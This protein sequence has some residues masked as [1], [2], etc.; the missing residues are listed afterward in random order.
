MA[1]M[2][3]DLIPA[4][5]GDEAPPL[6]IGGKSQNPA[7]QASTDAAPA[8]GGMF[9]DLVP[10]TKPTVGGFAP[11]S[12]REA[13][14]TREQTLD[15]YREMAKGIRGRQGTVGKYLDTFARGVARVVPV[16]DDIAAAGDYYLPKD[17]YKPTSYQDALDRVRAMNADDDEHR[18]WT[19]TAGTVAGSL[20]TLP[21]LPGG[22]AAK[23]G[24]AAAEQAGQIAA[25]KT[26]AMRAAD[27]GQIAKIGAVYGGLYGFGQGDAN[28][29]DRATKTVVGAGLGSVIAPV[30]NAVLTPAIGLAARGAN[31]AGRGIG[32]LANRIGFGKTAEAA[33][34]NEMASLADEFGVNLS[35]G[36]RTG[37]GP[38]I[39]R[40]NAIQ[41]GA[42]GPLAQEEAMLSRDAQWKQINEARDRIGGDLAGE[43]G[44]VDTPRDAGR[45]VADS[46]A[47]RAAAEENSLA[48]RNAAQRAVVDELNVAVPQ[49]AEKEAQAVADRLGRQSSMDAA[50]DVGDALRN[51]AEAGRAQYRAAY[52]DAMERPGSVAPEFF[53][54]VEN[55]AGEMVSPTISQ[56]IQSRLLAEGENPVAALEPAAAQ[57]LDDL[58]AFSR[59]RIGKINDPSQEVQLT[60][61]AVE[62]ARKV[63]QRR[64][65]AASNDSDKRSMRK[66]IG[67]FDDEV[68]NMLQSRLYSGDPG[69]LN[70]FR[71][72]RGLYRSFQQQFRPQG[73]GDDVG[74]AL[75]RIVDHNATPEEVSNLL[76]GGSAVGARGVNARLVERVTQLFGKDSEQVQAI[77][78][79]VWDRIV[80][81][82][83][84]TSP[85]DAEKIADRIREFTQGYGRSV[86]QALYSPDELANM[87]TLQDAMRRFSAWQ[88]A[89]FEAQEAEGMTRS[90]IDIARKNF[91]PDDLA[92]KLVGS[93]SASSRT[94]NMHA[95]GVVEA[96]FGK[97]SPE[98]S[99]V[100]QAMWK[101]T[102]TKPDGVN[103]FGSQALSKRIFELV[104]GRG[105][106]IAD[107]L[108]TPE[109]IGEMRRFATLV[110]GTVTEGK[111]GI[112]NN[113]GTFGPMAHA[114]MKRNI[115]A[116]SA[117]IGAAV[118]GAGGAAA[119]VG[120][121]QGL[122]KIIDRRAAAAAR[123][124]F[125]D[126]P[127]RAAARR[128][129]VQSIG[130]KASQL[131]AAIPVDRFRGAA[132][133]AAGRQAGS[134]S[135]AP[136]PP[137]REGDRAA[138]PEDRPGVLA[139]FGRATALGARRAAQDVGQ[140]AT[141]AVK[142]LE[143]VKDWEAPKD[144]A[145][146]QIAGQNWRQGITDPRWLAAKVGEGVGGSSPALAGGVAGLAGGTAV[147]GPVGG[148]VGA[149]GGGALGAAVQTVAPA[150]ARARAAG[151]NHDQAVSVALGETAVSAAGGGAGALA[152]ALRVARGPIS[153]ALAQLFVVQPGIGLAQQAGQNAVAGRPTTMDE[154]VEGYITNAGAGAAMH[155][156]MTAAQRAASM[157]PRRSPPPPP[158]PRSRIEP[159]FDVW[160]KGRPDDGGGAPPPGEGGPQPPN[161]PTPPQQPTH[162]LTSAGAARG[163]MA[164]PVREPHIAQAGPQSD[165]RPSPATFAGTVE[166][167]GRPTGAVPTYDPRAAR[168]PERG[169]DA[170]VFTF[171]AASLQTD[172]GRF[173]YKAGSDEA[174][175]L[176]GGEGLAS[177]S[178]W[179]RAKAGQA[180]V[181]EDPNGALFVV[182]G[183]QR[184]GLARRVRAADPQAQTPITGV[185]LR[186]RDGITATQA[187][188]IAALKNIAE[189]SGSM[190]DAAKVLR[191]QPEAFA[192]GSMPRAR[193]RIQ[194][195]EGLARLGDEP[196]GMVVNDVIAPTYGAIVGR[197]IPEP[198]PRQD[199]AMQLLAKADPSNVDE[200][201]ALVRQVAAEDVQVTPQADLFGGR[202]VAESLVLEKAKVL[203]GA[204]RSLGRE[205]A[206]FGALVKNADQ[207][208]GAGNRLAH[209]TN[210]GRRSDAETLGA[211]I[212]ADAFRKGDVGDAL[213][214]AAQGVRDGWSVRDASERFI[215]AVRSGDMGALAGD[216]PASG[217]AERGPEAPRP[218][219]RLPAE[220]PAPAARPI[221]PAPAVDQT[222][223]GPQT[224]IPG[225]EKAPDAK[226]A[227]AAADAPLRPKAPQKDTDGL[228]LMNDSAKQADLLDVKPAQTEKPAEPAKTPDVSRETAE[229]EPAAAPTEPE[230]KPVDPATAPETAPV[231]GQKVPEFVPWA[232]AKPG[233]RL[234]SGETLVQR[235]I[236]TK[237]EAQEI[238]TKAPPGRVRGVIGD[239]IARWAVTEREGLTGTQGW[240]RERAALVEKGRR[241]AED[242]SARDAPP[243]LG[244]DGRAAWHEG[245]DAVKAADETK[246][247]G[248]T[249]PAKNFD[250]K[251]SPADAVADHFARGNGFDTIVQARKF[252][253]ENGGKG[254]SIKQVDEAIEAGVVKVARDIAARAETP[255][256]AYDA[257]VDL[258]A[259]QPRLGVRTSTSVEQ[260]AYSTPAPLA[261][262]ASRAAGIDAT[263][264]V[265]EPTAGNGI[266][267]M[268]TNPKNAVV[269]EL[270]GAR[271]AVLRA[272][273]FKVTQ[274]DASKPGTA[275][276]AGKVDAVIAN[277]PFGTVKEADGTTTRRFDMKDVQPGYETAEIDH[278]IALRSLG[279]M[280]DDGRAVLILGSVAKTAASEQARSDAYHGKAKREFFKV[281][282][283]NYK[284]SDHYTVSG[285]LYA[286][287]GAGWPVD[288]ITIEGRGKSER[289]LPAVKTPEIFNNWDNLGAKLDEQLPATDR[290]STGEEAR[291]P[292]GERAPPA[293]ADLPPADA[294][295]G[296]GPERGPEP[297]AADVR[298]EPV[299]EPGA[300]S[301]DDNAS[302]RSGSGEPGRPDPEN[303]AERRPSGLKNSETAE[304]ETQVAYEPRSTSGKPLGTLVPKNMRD[305]T[306]NALMSLADDVGGDID[307]YVAKT[308][309]LTPDEMTKTLA[310][311][312]IDALGLALH[313]IDKGSAFI[314]G[315]QTGIGK[316]RVNAMIIRHAI[317]SGRTPIF[318]TEKPNLYGD[319]WRDLKD[320]NIQ[321]MLGRDPKILMTNENERIP[322][323]PDPDDRNGPAI[324]SRADLREHMQR[325]MDGA[326]IDADA[327]FTTYNQM[328]TVRGE[329]TLRREFIDHIA[330]NAIVI[331]DES[332]NAGGQGTAAPKK[333]G[334]P[335]NRAEF[336]RRIAEKAQGVFFSSA[337]FAKN[338]DV[339]DLYAKTDMGLAVAKISDLSEAIKKGGVPLQEAI[340]SMLAEAGQYI[341]RE[342]SFE[343]VTYDTP[344]IPFNRDT[345]N[346][347]SESLALI[348][349][350]SR[351]VA[352]ATED[353]HNE[354]K[355]GAA[356]V[357]HDGSTGGAGAESTNFTSIMHNVINQMLLSAK[358]NAAADRAIEALRNGEKPVITVAGT[359][360]SFLNDYADAAGITPGQKMTG[361]FGDVLMRY[362]DRSRVITIKEPFSK[363]GDHI[364]KV[365]T[366]DELG[367]DG[368][369]AY[370]EARAFIS[371][372]DFSDLPI[373]PI[374]NM[375]K[376]LRDAG[377]K[378]GEITG[379]GTIIDYANGSSYKARPL[380]EKSILGRIKTIG[381]FN[382]G[383]IDA[384]ILNQAGATGLSLHASDKFANQQR[385]R[386]IIAQ[387]EGNVDVHMQ[388]LGRV[389]RTG[390]VIT[391]AYDQLTLDI[392]A[393][394]RPAAVL[395]KKMA[396]LNAATTSSRKGALASDSAIDFLNVYGD[397]VA[398]RFLVDNPQVAFKLGNLQYDAENPSDTM[399]RLTGRIP[400]L[401]VDTQERIYE[402]LVD[403]YQR[404]VAEADAAGNNV[405]EAKFLDLDAKPI[406]KVEAVP[407]KGGKSP[408]SAPVYA[409]TFD[410]KRMRKPMTPKT[411][412][413]TIH[414]Q[415]IDA[416]SPES[417]RTAIAARR[418]QTEA[419][420]NKA[421][422]D[423]E[424]FSKQQVAG[425]VSPEAASNARMRNSDNL[426]N[427]RDFTKML[428][429][430]S[431]V[432]LTTPDGFPT[433]ALVL[434]FARTGKAQNPLALGS[435]EARLGIPGDDSV[436]VSLA[437]LSD[438]DSGLSVKPRYED[439]S[440][441]LQRAE[442]AS[443]ESREN[444]VIL[445]GNMLAAFNYLPGQ[446]IRFK[447]ADGTLKQGVMMPAK[448][449]TA[450][451]L[452][453][454]RAR[455]LSPDEAFQHMKAEN[456]L[457]DSESSVSLVR[458]P[459]GLSVRVP[460]SK[461]EGGRFY[462]NRQVL[463]AT[464]GDFTSRGNVMSVD[465]DESRALRVI[466]ALMDA[467]ATFKATPEK[468][469]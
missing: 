318:V 248:L 320:T 461:R 438:P 207:I 289:P 258:Y 138:P 79:G 211:R 35:R 353:I 148:L 103:E 58:A 413:E 268:E 363:K 130:D 202:D 445:T 426:Q 360:E 239:G 351:F 222:E 357:S 374:D 51:R 302:Q 431:I 329:S 161:S 72:A 316:G 260:Q 198:G 57:A 106:T 422:G 210:A 122:K 322:V 55:E 87:R 67:A 33:A 439:V 133:M 3:D 46:I 361:T 123:K 81:N 183:H 143:A 427:F 271:A 450:K 469:R 286:K 128:W 152:P 95:L 26:L 459:R 175:V 433:S 18:Y 432:E 85:K 44:V 304:T 229:A 334:A 400:L 205:R 454:S 25:K 344:V 307:G 168:A 245:W 236:R 136:L 303:P 86:A 447:A 381:A 20:A 435:W 369:R 352:K 379:R 109:Q 192:D 28:L 272:Q 341:R 373:S 52:Q 418:P 2:F 389:H 420:T 367:P 147:A 50:Q 395:A 182:D 231:T 47:Q 66:I 403:E 203:A 10:T 411:M 99:A 277:P 146:D 61:Q 376:R 223:A 145:I 15:A 56:R 190:I 64:F 387:A 71:N 1:G 356:S 336:A 124:L 36:Q 317:R 157:L 365:L 386:M 311:E 173:Q 63:L 294:P 238:A 414:G 306:Q 337:T 342:R 390:Q 372:L 305:A 448:F 324:T 31:A 5:S 180:L 135:A 89:K 40:E 343:G 262:L 415:Q 119:G 27:V 100:A 217:G 308:L 456:V 380:S 397:T 224:V 270:N 78:G 149:V 98:M 73:T 313:N 451:S 354:V 364:K 155:G 82:L 301:D 83:E 287:Q 315:D 460:A 319:M 142:G 201:R 330:P 388:M 204:Q 197:L 437:S 246:R 62:D 60:M 218:P 113:S 398:A 242:G 465:I 59:L 92:A 393:E 21:L 184:A 94:A 172:P 430:G 466:K 375:H 442:L 111:K 154:L 323:G 401:D 77:R 254:L 166:A 462:L 441:F 241:A 70:A 331:F 188:T 406:D 177:V 455:P 126:E 7:P 463:D 348:N 383:A 359:M 408:F 104:N 252:V 150:Y 295:D 266:L 196:F 214:R 402:Q 326:P 391:P 22:A 378:T 129:A 410:V 404:V 464:G 127:Q 434:D 417:L 291:I 164:G 265:Y 68:E 219:A 84:A 132:I 250:P 171:D 225:A 170:G 419:V 80:G 440:S 17:N 76:Y 49:A 112:D 282:Y 38:T 97:N 209:E 39:A 41:R 137:P 467:G 468:G 189:G 158:S 253:D 233:D 333:A 34:P 144:A 140:S 345:Y 409:E 366:D 249:E 186:A 264:T 65:R 110:K 310:P 206:T 153:N 208:E 193:E 174:G 116:I 263:T 259:R 221:E 428:Q 297:V 405:L 371:S 156:G 30:A 105:R 436:R 327:I 42:D 412:I 370:N 90:L 276:S 134:G 267:L 281:L 255:R 293:D 115:E 232:D 321:D 350:F 421:I 251:A 399:R 309:G 346:S 227:Q 278:A 179:D 288:V 261:Y 212:E 290:G 187:R 457:T 285:D 200:A 358:S 332:H 274:F 213:T 452:L 29:T 101:L 247:S 368:L 159:I 162:P 37:H 102:T 43:H 165:G 195:I 230:A 141:A 23:S 394:K 125:N 121:A 340:S 444:R 93:N 167:M 325:V 385:R 108:Y 273:G 176:S 423:F 199:A 220:P 384:V 215:Q 6:T 425:M 160:P 244:H 382:S 396:S 362:L 8:S 216:R 19:G 69:T 300:R 243:D 32:A 292:A 169:Q 181:W 377:Y 53:A 91:S 296:R 16:M 11:R 54:G 458:S 185:L 269:N 279:A 74:R 314:I 120:A 284:V 429:P 226:V 416:A 14:P 283:D 256:A 163:A 407:G 280:K 118:G 257:L 194:D 299:A 12:A 335:D 449:K 298:G 443:K 275:R 234:A 349:E 45:V 240:A 355:A 75:V 96:T 4:P 392:P 88:P 453:G 117:G 312:Q 151:M 339:M 228:P 191:D 328:Q 24:T 347:F 107:R 139:T 131:A 178:R 446:I 9:D 114:F 235:R 424:A 13:E 48:A 237:R 338:P